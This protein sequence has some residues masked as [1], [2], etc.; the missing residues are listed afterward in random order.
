MFLIAVPH[1][2]GQIDAQLTKY[3]VN[4]AK[5]FAITFTKSDEIIDNLKKQKAF[6]TK[7]DFIFQSK[8][9]W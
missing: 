7:E 3:F 9:L 8:G 6:T 4:R 2:M 1:T 5:A